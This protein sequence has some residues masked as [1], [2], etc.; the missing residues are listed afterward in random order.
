[1]KPGIDVSRPGSATAPAPTPTAPGLLRERSVGNEQD[2]HTLAEDLE[3][4]AA[5]EEEK[6]GAQRVSLA[7]LIEVEF[8]DHFRASRMVLA[9]V[10]T[11]ATMR[12]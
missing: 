5:V 9:A 8:R 1:M 7:I 11:A 10:R 6:R 12:W 4:G 3:K 2:E